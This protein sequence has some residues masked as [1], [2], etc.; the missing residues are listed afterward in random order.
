MIKFNE[1]GKF[2][3]KTWADCIEAQGAGYLI[4]CAE[5]GKGVKE[6]IILWI[7][8]KYKIDAIND[9]IKDGLNCGDRWTLTGVEV[10]NIE[11]PVKDTHGDN[12]FVDV[13]YPIVKEIY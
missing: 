13:Y 6:E 5:D 4:V 9:I 2:H 3:P 7:I 12:H 10:K 8:Y 1:E 11:L